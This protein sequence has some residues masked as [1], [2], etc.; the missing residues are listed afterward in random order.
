M[1]GQDDNIEKPVSGGD[2]RDLWTIVDDLVDYENREWEF[3]PPNIAK[4]I[5]SDQK[6][7]IVMNT[8]LFTC[9]VNGQLSTVSIA[10]P[11]IPAPLPA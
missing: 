3:K 8:I 11:D 5:T 2:V 10:V 9:V 1:R 4:I 6:V 7:S